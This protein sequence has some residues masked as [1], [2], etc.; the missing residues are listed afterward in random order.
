MKKPVP[1]IFICL[2]ALIHTCFAQCPAG[3][4]KARLKWDN[5]D[6]YY[7]GGIGV[8]PYGSSGGTYVTNAMEQSQKF[9]I[10]TASINFNCS[11]AG[12]VKGRN[13]RHTGNLTN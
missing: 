10:G 8:A 4:T 9:T 13:T 7:N 3:Y 11:A 12:V 6:Y 1:A 5:L 2:L